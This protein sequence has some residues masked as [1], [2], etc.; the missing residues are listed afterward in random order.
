MAGKGKSVAVEAAKFVGNCAVFIVT[1]SFAAVGW[2]IEQLTKQRPY[3]ARDG[4][5]Y[6]HKESPHEYHNRKAQ[7]Y[8][9]EQARLERI[10]ASNRRREEELRRAEEDLVRA[11]QGYRPGEGYIAS[12]GI[13]YTRKETPEECHQRRLSNLRREADRARGEYE[14]GR[15]KTPP[16]GR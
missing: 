3:R 11:R 15:G 5:V 12:N 6:T 8:E 14:R 2:V 10:E 16:R 1:A 4:H 9:Q 7:K 13:V